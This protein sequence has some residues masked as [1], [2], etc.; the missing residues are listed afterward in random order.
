MSGTRAQLVPLIS[1]PTPR[2]LVD[3]GSGAGFPG[4]V[5]ADPAAA[6][7]RAWSLYEAIAKKCRFLEEVAASDAVCTSRSATA[8]RRRR[9]ASRSTS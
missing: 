1:G 4:L 6:A 7:E 5:L 8:D 3:L 2:R 9:S